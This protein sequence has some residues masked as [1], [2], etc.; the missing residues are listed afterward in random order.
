MLVK[1]QLRQLLIKSGFWYSL[2]LIR[3]L[4]EILQW[5]RSGCS[6]IA[7]RP[8]KM[9]VVGAYLRQFSLDNFVETGTYLGDTL[10]Y[11]ARSGARCTSIELSRELYEAARRR[12]GGYKNVKL[13]QGGSAQELPELLREINEPT[14]FWLDGHYSSGITACA[15]THTPIKFELQVLLN[16]SVRN[17]VILIDDARYF[18]GRN[19]YPHLDDLLREVRENRRYNAEVSTDIIR[20]IPRS[21]S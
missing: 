20:L 3:N 15:E 14:L 21:M 4:P 16:H 2:S 5:L 12:F 6:G 11:I 10:G 18:D 8:I 17:H 9:M 13:V 19:D 7:P 1:R